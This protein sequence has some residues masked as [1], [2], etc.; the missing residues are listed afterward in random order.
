MVLAADLNGV[1]VG[2][3]WFPSP[4]RLLLFCACVSSVCVCVGFVTE[5]LDWYD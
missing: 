2:I 5:I 1:D 3:R 4:S